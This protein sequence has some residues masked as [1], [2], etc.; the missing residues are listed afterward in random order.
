MLVALYY[1]GFFA[2]LGVFLP[3]FSLWLVGQGLTATEAT[4]VLALTP[5]MGLLA[6]PLFGLWA[7]ARRARVWLLRACSL[8]TF[9]AFLG[10]FVAHSR[11]ALYLTTLLFALFRSP[12]IPLTDSVALEHVRRHGGSYGQLRLWG[13]LGF[14]GAVWAGGILVETAGLTA[15]VVTSAQALAV[16]AACA[17]AMPQPPV[18]HRPVVGAWLALLE[19]ADW[20]ILFAAIGFGQLATAAY[21]SGFTLHLAR[22]GFRG[23]FVGTAWAVGV[24]AEI[25]LMALS[26]RILRRV[27]AAQLLTLSF[28]TAVIRWSLLARVSSATAILCLQPLHGVTFGLFWVASVTLV[29]DRG[30]A[31]PTAAQGLLAAALGLGGIVGMNVTGALLD[32]GGGAL[33]YRSAAWAALAATFCAAWYAQRTRSTVAPM[34][35]GF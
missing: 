18:V 30:A 23:R 11:P 2:A 19:S 24:A 16:C 33:L 27:G 9:V 7:D 5:L 35:R 21:D 15:I 28:A 8:L 10:F 26:S 22:L 20:W 3:Y 6:P 29:R 34:G 4:R 31:A 32:A 1:F 12:L 14:L 13:S 25:G 17:W